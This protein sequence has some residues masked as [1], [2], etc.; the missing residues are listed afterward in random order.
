MSTYGKFQITVRVSLKRTACQMYTNVIISLHMV[1]HALLVLFWILK[2]ANFDENWVMRI[3]KLSIFRKIG[4][5][6]K[7]N[8]EKS[9]YITCIGRII[10]KVYSSGMN[11]DVWRLSKLNSI[12]MFYI[13]RSWQNYKN[14]NYRISIP[15]PMKNLRMK[16]HRKR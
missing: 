4:H 14:F 10:M 11:Q 12:S 8:T 2:I 6:F 13:R 16:S 7:I 15:L 1:H 3:S 5:F 9:P